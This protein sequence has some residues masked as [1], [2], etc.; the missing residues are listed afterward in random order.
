M[1][2]KSSLYY[3]PDITGEIHVYHEAHDGLIH[4]EISG[5]SNSAINVVL[6][7]E[8]WEVLRTCLKEVMTHVGRD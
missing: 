2:T 4:L 3:V 1:S 6:P 8:L 5:C 7:Q